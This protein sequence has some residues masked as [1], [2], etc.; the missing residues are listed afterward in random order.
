MKARRH[1][2]FAALFIDLEGTL[3][4][5]NAKELLKRITQAGREAKM[6][7]VVNFEHIKHATP[8]AIYTLFDGEILRAITPHTKLRYRNLKEAFQ[9]IVSEIALE[10]L[11]LF[12]EDI[13]HA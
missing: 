13:Q 12:D 3:D 7:I 8:K 2:A 9:S 6:D 10:N 4:H 11:D 1:D 5:L